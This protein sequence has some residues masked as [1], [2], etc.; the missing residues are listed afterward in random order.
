MSQTK[1]LSSHYYTQDFL[2][3]EFNQ[4]ILDSM[5]ADLPT[6]K[7]AEVFSHDSTGG[8]VAPETRVAKTAALTRKVREDFRAAVQAIL[9][10]VMPKVGLKMRDDFTFEISAALHHDGGFFSRHTDSRTGVEDETIR[11]A[12]AVYYLSRTPQHFLGGQ[13]RLHALM[14]DGHQDF[15]ATNNALMIFPS[16]APHEVLPISVPSGR[17]EDGRFSINCWVRIPRPGA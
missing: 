15:E 8:R 5:L 3:P 2:T 12:S 4:A 10:E 16:F 14:G 11:Y 7:D 13:F 6:F 9:P 1:Y 17:A